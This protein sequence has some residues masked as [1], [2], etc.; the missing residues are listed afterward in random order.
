MFG[1][2]KSSRE[3]FAF[4]LEKEMKETPGRRKEILDEVKGRIQEIKKTLREGT[5]NK[6]F[7]ELGILLQSYGALEKVLQKVK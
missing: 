7:N 6:E 2:E 1:F 4:D 5:N 3:K